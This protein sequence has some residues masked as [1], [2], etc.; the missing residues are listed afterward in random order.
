MAW[1][2]LLSYRPQDYQPVNGTIHNTLC[3]P[4][5][6]FNQENVQQVWLKCNLMGASSQRSLRLELKVKLTSKQ[7]THLA[8][9]L[10]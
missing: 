5:L 8:L 1:L 2:S 3:P 4:I 10:F 7:P 6:S 9:Q